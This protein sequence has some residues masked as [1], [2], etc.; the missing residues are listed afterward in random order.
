MTRKVEPQAQVRS[1][2]DRREFFRDVARGVM[3]S[4]VAAAT[5]VLAA[6]RPARPTQAACI[7]Q[8][9]CR[10]CSVLRT[11]GL[12]AALSTKHALEES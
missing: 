1:A 11:C 4:G 5:V 3:I 6:R 10:R 9:V 12:P 7:N 8:G 2:I